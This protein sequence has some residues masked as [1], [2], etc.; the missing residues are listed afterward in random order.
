M[1]FWQGQRVRLRAMEP[2][3]A[4]IFY[5]RYL[6]SEGAQHGTAIALEHRRKGYAGEALSL[7]LRYYT[8]R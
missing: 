4:A 2:G 8:W 5:E 1:S 6:D 7:M 3:D